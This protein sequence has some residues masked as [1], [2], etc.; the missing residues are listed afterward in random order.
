[1]QDVLNRNPQWR[2]AI[3]EKRNTPEGQ[4]EV[5]MLARIADICRGY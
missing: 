5:A 4:D 2:T 3:E 1:L